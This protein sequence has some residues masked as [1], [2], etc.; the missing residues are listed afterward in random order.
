VPFLNS[1]TGGVG[2][3]PQPEVN[4]VYNQLPRGY[5]TGIQIIQNVRLEAYVEGSGV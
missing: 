4:P 5:G 2:L 3:Y 1:W